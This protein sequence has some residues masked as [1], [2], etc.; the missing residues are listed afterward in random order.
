ML[1]DSGRLH[2]RGSGVPVVKAVPTPTPSRSF[3]RKLYPSQFRTLPPPPQAKGAKIDRLE[4]A[5]WFIIGMELE[6]QER[7]LN[8]ERTHALVMG[9]RL[10][11]LLGRI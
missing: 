11:T 7:H 1:T 9:V 2:L 4:A 3:L 6:M 5:R 8:Y 10:P